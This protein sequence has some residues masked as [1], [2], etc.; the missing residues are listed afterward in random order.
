MQSGTNPEILLQG[1]WPLGRLTIVN[2]TGGKG[3]SKTTI[4]GAQQN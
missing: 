3:S 2:Y 1:K 4:I